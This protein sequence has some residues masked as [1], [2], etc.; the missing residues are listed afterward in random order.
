MAMHV[1]QFF[2]TDNIKL[3]I[4]V[5]P[6]K[7]HLKEGEGWPV[8]FWNAFFVCGFLLVVFMVRPAPQGHYALHF[9]TSSLS[10]VSAHIALNQATEYNAKF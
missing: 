7:T 4:C 5:L 2:S 8:F 6:L 3:S 9:K 1:M 10:T